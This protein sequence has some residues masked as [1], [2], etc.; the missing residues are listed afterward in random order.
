MGN[1]IVCAAETKHMWDNFLNAE[2]LAR[3]T[4]KAAA[5]ARLVELA[6]QHPAVQSFTIGRC[7]C[8]GITLVSGPTNRKFILDSTK[9]N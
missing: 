5:R 4:S 7:Y 6:K 2:V 9:E 1:F 3:T 8:G